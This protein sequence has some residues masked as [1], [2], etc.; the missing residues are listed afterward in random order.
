MKRKF[1]PAN[2]RNRRLSP[3][4][5]LYISLPEQLPYVLCHGTSG[6]PLLCARKNDNEK[7]PL[8]LR[9]RRKKTN[10]SRDVWRS[11]V[12]TDDMPTQW[13]LFA[14]RAYFNSSSQ[15]TCSLTRKDSRSI[16]ETE[17]GFSLTCHGHVDLILRLENVN[18]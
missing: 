12:T 10:F 17:R 16:K 7:S 18:V 11:I 6:E 15:I 13:Q 5:T 8:P 2:G 3:N 1:L 4:V 9:R 14:S